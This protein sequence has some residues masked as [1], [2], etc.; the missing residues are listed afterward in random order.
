VGNPKDC[1]LFSAEFDQVLSADSNPL[2]PYTWET[3]SY[4]HMLIT[5]DSS[6]DSADLQSML[7]YRHLTTNEK[8]HWINS[9]GAF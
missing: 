4:F 9:N 1:P 7:P 3:G 6:L 8:P 2:S 5:T